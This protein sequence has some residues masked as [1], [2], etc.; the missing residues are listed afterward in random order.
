MTEMTS[1]VTT[2]APDASRDEL[3]SAGRRLPY[4][5]LQFSEDGEILVRGPTLFQG[6]LRQDG[7]LDP[8][9]D[10]DGWYHTRD[11][12]YRD[13]D[14]LLHVVG[15]KD[16]LFISGGENIQPEEI[17]D[18]L[19]RLPG[20]TRAVVVPVP[21][22]EFGERPVAFVDGVPNERLERLASELDGRLSRFKIPDA[23]YPWPTDGMGSMKVDRARLQRVARKGREK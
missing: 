3:R 22:A 7:S 13:Q 21:D 4:R 10:A 16:H 15:R 9:V 17:E 23:F 20:V 14:G 12:G 6:Y 18:V 5:E 19:L 2:T 11:L 1:Q 8:G